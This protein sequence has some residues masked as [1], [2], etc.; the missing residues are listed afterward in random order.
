VSQLGFLAERAVRLLKTARWLPH[1]RRRAWLLEGTEK[2]SGEPLSVLCAAGDQ[3]RGYL[4]Q[5]LFREGVRES[6]LGSLWLWE[7]ASS[8][9]ARKRGCSLVVIQVEPFLRKLLE[10]DDWFFIP[11][12]VVGTV[13]LPIPAKAL[14]HKAIRSDLQAIE[15][16]GLQSR[17]TRELELF[18]DFYHAMYVPHVTKA[19]AASVYVTPYDE[20]RAR[21][22]D[23]ELVLVHDE[24]RD[25][26]G[27]LVLYE[28]AR[29]RLW[30]AGVRD[31]DRR[32]LKQGA[33]SAVYH[34]SLQHLAG[35]QF[36]SASLGL[37]RAFLNDGVLR[38]K[39]KWGQ[40]LAGTAAARI[41]LKVV[42]DTPASRACLQSNPFVFET[43]GTL[44]GAVFLAHQDAVTADDVNRL[45]KQYWHDGLSK[46]ILF[47]P[48][49]GEERLRIDM[50]AD[51]AL[52]AYREPS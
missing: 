13:A 52:E 18:D 24:E 25:V 51:V 26:A 30:S 46:L 16:A 8:R 4:T 3:T 36:S 10:E 20:M 12:W 41:A 49:A 22:P 40:T 9:R 37:S 35:K 17:V 23:S 45:R 43:S 33:L 38:Y 2:S 19:H 32:Y 7:L 42:A 21:L 6:D 29:P 5:L 31:G 47:S 11:L 27:M 39:R 48:R 14:K 50:P 15:H 34:Y 1:L 44:Y 28:E